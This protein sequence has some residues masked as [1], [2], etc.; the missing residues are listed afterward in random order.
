MNGSSSWLPDAYYWATIISSIVAIFAFII[1]FLE[2]D[3]KRKSDGSKTTPFN[4]KQETDGLVFTV[5]NVS[6]KM[7]RVEGDKF[8]MGS[9]KELDSDAYINEEPVHQVSVS[10]YYIGQTEVTQSL[11][12][13]VMKKQSL[14]EVIMKIQSLR[15]L[16]V[17]IKSLWIAFTKKQSLW[18]TF[19]NPSYF[20]GPNRPVESVSWN[21]CQEFI[22]KLN[23]QTRMNFR[24]PTEE[25]WEYAARGGKKSDK[26]KYS[27]SDI[28]EDVARYNLNSDNHT[29][30]VE[31]RNPNELGLYDMSGN[32]WEWCGDPYRNYSNS[33]QTN[34]F[35]SSA[36]GPS[37][38]LRG[39]SWNSYNQ[40][41]RVS[42]RISCNPNE[43]HFNIGFRLALSE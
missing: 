40:I 1:A 21:D 26:F 36:D 31:S 11:W 7:V 17:K 10:S 23:Q 39:G 16:V 3:R 2:F 38:V 43:R 22:K 4:K 19:I 12:E 8:M 18:L 6:F 42:F 9:S 33:V 29:W 20:K 28:L 41:C 14:W 34:Q 35:V 5:G 15:E 30:N 37:L 27:G 32:V 25:E 13:V 24:L